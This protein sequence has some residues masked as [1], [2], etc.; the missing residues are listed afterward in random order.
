VSN[1][2]TTRFVGRQARQGPG[3]TLLTRLSAAVGA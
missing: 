2:R 3:T 1:T